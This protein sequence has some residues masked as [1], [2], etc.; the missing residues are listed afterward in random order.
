MVREP[1]P[2]GPPKEIYP[3]WSNLMTDRD[4]P[5]YEINHEEVKKAVQLFWWCNHYDDWGWFEFEP[6]FKLAKNVITIWTRWHFG[7][8]SDR[9]RPDL[10]NWR[11]VLKTAKEWRMDVEQVPM[12][13]YKDTLEDFMLIYDRLSRWRQMP[14]ER[15]IALAD[16]IIYGEHVSGK[17]LRIDVEGLRERFDDRYLNDIRRYRSE[18]F[19]HQTGSKSPFTKGERRIAVE[20]YLD[21]ESSYSIAED[22]KVTART[23]LNWVED[24]G[25]E[26][27]GKSTGT[28]EYSEE[29]KEKIVDEYMSGKSSAELEEEYN[30]SHGTI[31]RWIRESEYEVRH[32]YSREFKDK[33]VD[34]YVF[35]GKTSKEL[36]ERY[37]VGRQTVTEWVKQAGYDPQKKYH[38]RPLLND[39][40]NE[41][42]EIKEL[43]DKYGMT[44]NGIKKHIADFSRG[45]LDIGLKENSRNYEEEY[46]GRRSIKKAIED[47]EDDLYMRN[48]TI[49]DLRKRDRSKIRDYWLRMDT[50]MAEKYI[51]EEVLAWFS[52][53]D[54]KTMSKKKLR[55]NLD[56]IKDRCINEFYFQ[57]GIEKYNYNFHNPVEEIVDYINL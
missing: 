55:E 20:R 39:Y 27:R 2:E 29:F 49:K 22:Y 8:V 36:S 3:D 18:D 5:S 48:S 10:S 46:S 47:T 57:R 37:D 16:S 30:I 9:L 19:P 54:Q 44:P 25:Y 53:L 12:L 28:N 24:F 43:A 26:T 6:F 32:S 7:E 1:T 45:E 38:L 40:F 56:S 4:Y 21:G 17:L 14:L 15:K 51:L 42:L 33:I 34:K 35:E 13:Q 52:T 11:E 31:I 50:K 41:G 23:I